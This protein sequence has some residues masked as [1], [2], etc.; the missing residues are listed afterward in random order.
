MSS[1]ERGRNGSLFQAPQT[2]VTPQVVD[3]NIFGFAD[4]SRYALVEQNGTMEFG[5]FRMSPLGLEIGNQVTQDDWMHVGALL[6][7]MQGAIQ[8][9]VGDWMAYGEREYKVSYEQASEQFGYRKKTL[10]NYAS[11]CKAVHFSL[12]RE[13][14]SFTHHT[15][16]VDK[17]PEEQ[18][19]WLERAEVGNWSVSQMR[20]EM[21]QDS[22]TP[23]RGIAK[24]S[25]QLNDWRART[26]Q[27]LR[28][29][30]AGKS[31]KR[32][33]LAMLEEQARWIEEWTRRLRQ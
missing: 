1:R 12:R 30:V 31:D 28:R 15:L 19:L 13:K 17:S 20:R 18:S 14:L 29:A 33:A 16:V 11:V 9:L 2:Q 24:H 7:R 5:A 32:E 8:W 22:P 4:T 27:E 25:M 23:L 3:Q 21:R 10:Y 6:H 26:E